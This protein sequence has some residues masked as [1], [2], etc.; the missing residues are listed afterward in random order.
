MKLAL[1]EKVI[2][3]GAA[4]SLVVVA[5]IVLVG[6]AGKNKKMGNQTKRLKSTAD[7]DLAKWKGK[8]ELDPSLSDT[9]LS[10]WKVVGLHFTPSQMQSS[11]FQSK[12]PWSAAYVSHL[13]TNS[14]FENF[15][16]RSFHSTYVVDAKENKTQGRKPSYWA[17]KPQEKKVEVGDIIVKNRGGNSYTYDSIVRGVPT[18][19]DVVVDMEEKS[20][21]KYAVIQGGNVS[22]SVTRN[23][24][25]LNDDGTL[26]LKYIAHLKYTK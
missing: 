8:K 14:G 9:L 22:N 23:S 16:P 13:I 12:H 24:V 7:D 6:R 20:G 4:A 21:K 10:Y 26:P 17:F 1:K 11:S 2:I 19:G 18:H 25:L 5:I 3:I 15:T